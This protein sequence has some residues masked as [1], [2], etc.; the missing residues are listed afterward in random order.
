MSMLDEITTGLL[1]FLGG[2]GVSDIHKKGERGNLGQFDEIKRSS[3][4]V[5]RLGGNSR[6]L[7]SFFFS[8]PATICSRET[9]A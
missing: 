8:R 3:A 4:G 5:T 1:F 9:P 6:K 7:I 2:V